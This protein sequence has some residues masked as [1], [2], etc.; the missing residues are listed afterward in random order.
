[1]HKV[2]WQIIRTF[3]LTSI[4][5]VSTETYSDSG[6]YLISKLGT[7]IYTGIVILYY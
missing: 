7:L 5:C 1:M 2:Q 3:V 4:S 6:A